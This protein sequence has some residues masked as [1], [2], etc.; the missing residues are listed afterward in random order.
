LIRSCG[1]KG[2]ITVELPEEKRVEAIMALQDIVDMAP[3]V[4]RKV[5][6]QLTGRL[7]WLAGL[8]PQLR[9]FTQVLWAALASDGASMKHVFFKQIETAIVWFQAFLRQGSG[10]LTRTVYADPPGTIPVVAFDASPMGGGAVLWVI[11]A[12]VPVTVK[13]LEQIPAFAY[14][15]LPWTQHH[16][17]LVNA[18][19]GDPAGQARWE[20]LALLIA[21]RTWEKVI[22]T[23]RGTP[24]AIGDALGMLHGAAKFRSKDVM[25][26]KIFQEIALLFA[27]A[28]AVLDAMHIWSE[29]N[30]VAD[31]LSRMDTEHL[32]LP[33]IL[34]KVRRS[35]PPAM[36][37]WRFGGGRFHCPGDLIG[38]N[39]PGRPEIW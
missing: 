32:D 22:F 27:P 11:K 34:A 4:S 33:N 24:T 5:L 39:G 36:E 18:R 15:H 13:T 25:I 28:G 7:E 10:L 37:I 3:K 6:R 29:E 16:E 30:K 26:N 17:T 12:D 38:G 31:T 35:P 14:L 8:L 1:D 20:A 2:T 21:L 23:S 19:I 9:P